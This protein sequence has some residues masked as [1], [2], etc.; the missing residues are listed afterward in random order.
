MRGVVVFLWGGAFVAAL[1][2]GAAVRLAGNR[3]DAPTADEAL[4]EVKTQNAAALEE[5]SGP[6]SRFGWSHPGPLMF[7][8]QA[9]FYVLGDRRP[10]SLYAGGVF[11]NLSFITL[12][13]CAAWR[14]GTCSAM[15]GAAA[16][17]LVAWR[18]AAVLASPWNPHLLLFPWL[19][20]ITCGGAWAVHGGALPLAAVVVCG[21]W[22]AQTH[23]GAGPSVLLF[24]LAMGALHPARMTTR[25]AAVALAVA[26]LLWAPVLA[27]VVRHGSESN[28]WQ[29]AGWFA[30]DTH[31]HL[32]LRD[33]L[34]A[35]GESLTAFVRPQPVSVPV[36]W[37]WRASGRTAQSWAMACGALLVMLLAVRRAR[38]AA[39]LTASVLAGGVYTAWSVRGEM[40]DHL[41]F[42][43]GGGVPALVVVALSSSPGAAPKFRRAAAATLALAFLACAGMA[44]RQLALEPVRTHPDVS[45]ATRA[46]LDRLG[47][48][49]DRAV[50]D[51]D[52]ESWGEAAG[53]VAQL[54]REHHGIRVPPS[55]GFMYG[56]AATAD[57]DR[58]LARVIIR[59]EDTAGVRRMT[60]ARGAPQIIAGALQ[61]WLV[62]AGGE[63][64]R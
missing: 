14:L 36:G 2:I 28:L 25:P 33:A 57:D 21:T 38:A 4:I 47:H 39:V 53:I 58:G 19:A 40:V 55:L 22:L 16:V 61:I 10:A 50:V 15:A 35:A 52:D 56:R 17:C 60:E 1:L 13:L 30:R 41:L 8:A 3:I 31:G 62:R 9:P 43:L 46:L 20:L 29:I 27:D 7:Y 18:A 34:K 51:L 32:G 49:L 37:A 6:Y 12:A 24:I 54:R 42:W 48:E 44:M 5:T 45:L 26:L 11:I 63:R 59:R 23:V 64:T